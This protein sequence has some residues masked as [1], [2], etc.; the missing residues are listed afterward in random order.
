MKIH[1]F[2]PYQTEELIGR[3]GM[4]TVYR[5]IHQET[6]QVVAVKVLSFIHADDDNFRDRFA[7]EIETLKKLRHPNIVEL[8][9][10]GVQDGH[11]FYAMELIEGSSLQQELDSGQRFDWQAT[12]RIAIEIC[13]A[14]KHAHDRGVIHRDLKPANLLLAKDDQVKL[15]D[16]GIAKLFG[17][18]QITADRTVIGTADYMAPEQAEGVKASAKSDL[19]S[20][21][22]V[23]YALVTGKPPFAASTLAKVL[24]DL[25]NA[26]P[27]P[28]SNQMPQIPREFDEIVMHLLQKEPDQRYATALALANH[29]RAMEHA[30]NRKTETAQPDSPEEAQTTIDTHLTDPPS[31]PK[32]EIQDEDTRSLSP[33]VEAPQSSQQPA[34]RAAQTK[35][36]D[37]SDKSNRTRLDPKTPGNSPEQ[38]DHFI[39][40]DPNRPLNENQDRKQESILLTGLKVGISLILLLLSIAG[41]WYLLKPATESQLYQRIQA[42]VENNP[43]K[44]Q[45]SSTDIKLFLEKFPGSPHAAEIEGYQREIELQKLHRSFEQ[46]TRNT[47]FAGELSAPARAYLESLQESRT[48][49][50]VAAVKMQ[51]V[52]DVFSAMPDEE[53]QK[54]VKL[55]KLD[56]VQLTTQ[57]HQ[58]RSKS[59]KLLQ[60]RLQEADK[61]APQEA[62]AAQAIYRGIVV[63]Y[64]DKPWASEIVQEARQRLDP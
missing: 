5:G 45:R 1:N 6:R 32:V 18:H 28:L 9:G 37:G 56:L 57:I 55:A 34:S 12:T 24:S 8:Y 22:S 17:A 26:D 31:P 11:L 21:G 40:V 35:K 54:Y 30:V 50:E 62:A 58:R 42:V 64:A 27:V 49:Q 44:L 60:A 41:V 59:L 46:K 51:A 10:Y 43:D 2:G 48:N 63:L 23:M 20:L 38:P 61:I 7:L 53:S 29:L 19:Y 15:S 4:G 36:D 33:T 16:F 3:G 47:R 14:L 13:L 39:K 52:I 25:R